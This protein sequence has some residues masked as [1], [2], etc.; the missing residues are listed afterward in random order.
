M[1]ASSSSMGSY[2][3]NSSS[4]GIA[5][6]TWD[7]ATSSCSINGVS[8]VVV[9]NPPSGVNVNSTSAPKHNKAIL[10]VFA[11]RGVGDCSEAIST[12][13][14]HNL[15]PNYL[16]IP[17]PEPSQHCEFLYWECTCPNILSNEPHKLSHTRNALRHCIPYVEVGQGRRS[18]VQNCRW[19]REVCKIWSCSKNYVKTCGLALFGSSPAA[20]SL[21]TLCHANGISPF[22]ILSHNSEGSCCKCA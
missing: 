21:S 3:S 16:S 7:A 8:G 2:G 10:R 4:G 9:W 17:S 1:G 13:A 15:G 6:I 14:S 12:R 11:G 22:C 20:R 19:L 5:A 18:R